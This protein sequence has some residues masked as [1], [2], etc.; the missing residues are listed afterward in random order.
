MYWDYQVSVFVV[1]LFLSNT[2]FVLKAT[3]SVNVANAEFAMYIF[4]QFS[5]NFSLFLHFKGVS[6]EY[7]IALVISFILWQSLFF[8]QI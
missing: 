1:I 3:Q 5:L 7:H 4:L 8:K 6:Y 2:F